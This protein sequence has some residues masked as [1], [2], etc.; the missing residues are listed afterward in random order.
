[1]QVNFLTTLKESISRYHL[2]SH[3]FYKYYWTEGKLS[4]DNLANYAKQYYWQERN[5]IECLEKTASK[6]IPDSV[7]SVVKQNLNDEYGNGDDA[8]AHVKLWVNFAN[9][10]DVKHS[11]I[12]DDT[13]TPETQMLINT[14][15]ALSQESYEYTVGAM[16]AYEYQIPEI[17]KSK[18][19]GL[20]EHYGVTSESSLS[21]FKTH[22][23]ADV[24]HTKQW[25]SLIENFTENQK[26]MVKVGATIAAKALYR[27]LDGMMTKCN[28]ECRC[29]A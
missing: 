6:N 27:F 11:D 25:E 26:L 3:D 15:K 20:M 16:Y 17:A 23:E 5:F 9:E 10:F 2:L 13:M 21:F 1:M 24:W 14:Y 12:L 19:A 22:L 4:R 7:K 28:L 8:K 18:I 29:A